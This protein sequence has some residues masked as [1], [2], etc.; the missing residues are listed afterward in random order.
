MLPL[1]VQAQADSPSAKKLPQPVV[2]THDLMHLFNEPLYE[3]LKQAMKNQPSTDSQWK[4]IADRGRQAAEIANLV[5]IR[6]SHH[7]VDSWQQHAMDLQQAGK[8]LASTATS[9]DLQATRQAYRNLIQ[10]CNACHN[11]LGPG[12]APKL[13]P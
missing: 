12:H 5:A 7:G 11:Q 3:H 2:N 6:E 1:P 9:K 13:K 4:S 10:K 8:K